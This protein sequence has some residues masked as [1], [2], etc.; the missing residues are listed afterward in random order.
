MNI[1]MHKVTIYDKGTGEILSVSSMSQE[2][3]NLN[4]QYGYVYDRFG[5]TDNHYVV[6]GVSTHSRAKA[7]EAS[8]KK[9]M[10]QGLHTLVSL[11]FY[12]R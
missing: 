11:T 5:T 4:P 8:F 9:L 6:N 12:P 3:I 10:L 1:T 7:A 2:S